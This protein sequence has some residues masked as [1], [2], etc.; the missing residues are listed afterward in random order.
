MVTEPGKIPVMIPELNP[1]L[2]VEGSLLVHAPPAT[3]SV[4]VVAEPWQTVELPLITV[5][6]GLTVTITSAAQP[7]L[8][9]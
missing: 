9:V 2:A 3:P 1:T 5:G 6:N 8:K 4:N 7:V